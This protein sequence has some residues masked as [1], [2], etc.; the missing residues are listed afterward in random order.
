M[1]RNKAGKKVECGL[2]SLLSRLGG[3]YGFGRLIHGVIDAHKM[4][5]AALEQD[6]EIWGAEATPALV[7]YDR[8]G[9]ATT[10]R[11]RLAHDGVKHLGMQPKGQRPWH[12]AEDVRQ[13]VRSERGKTA[14]IIG[15]LKSNKD[16]FNKP[17]ERLWQT[18]EMAGLRSIVSFNLHKVMRDLV[19][20]RT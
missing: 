13:Q 15:T 2:P 9:E 1:V 5:L 14:G 12:V 16:G 11:T 19:Q 10:T 3:G 17:T 8:A 6:R 20:S 18:L 4:P 7:V